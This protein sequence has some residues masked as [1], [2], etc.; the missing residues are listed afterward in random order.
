[1]V[2]ISLYRGN[3]HRVPDAPR[4]WPMPPRSLTLE[5]FRI[6][7][8]KRGEALA[9]VAAA[10]AAQKAPK[11]DH[12][13]AVDERKVNVKEEPKEEEEGE[14]KDPDVSDPKPN[15]FDGETEVT[16]GSKM[17]DDHQKAIAKENASDAAATAAK[18]P[19]IGATEVK[20]E[21]RV[22]VIF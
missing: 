12:E 10:A 3:L 22:L 17:T 16:G 5:Q 6:L 18:G 11:P 21:V 9:R 15:K 1:M 13:K 8:R 20:V 4:R 19:D 2:A 14:V 7:S